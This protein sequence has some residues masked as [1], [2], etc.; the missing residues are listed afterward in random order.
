[1][2]E[3]SSKRILIV[4][5]D[6]PSHPYACVKLAK[7]LA[8]SGHDVTLGTPEGLARDQIRNGVSSW[9][10]SSSRKITVRTIGR[11]STSVHVNVRPVIDERSYSALLSG[12]WRPFPLAQKIETM[13]DEQEDLYRNLKLI[14]GEYD[15]VY[16]IHSVAGT[17]CDAV[18]S[19]YLT[20]G[21][22][23]P[24]I[25]FSSLPYDSSFYLG[26]GRD[27]DAWRMPRTI[28]ALPHV[29][30]YSS[31]KN[32]TNVVRYF[33]QLFWM[34][35]DYCLME[36]AWSRAAVRGNA[37]RAGRGLPPVADYR[38]YLQNYHV[39][40]F[41][42]VHPYVA[43]DER[44]AS[45]VTCIGAIDAR[46][47]KLDCKKE[48]DGVGESFSKWFRA[49][50][51]W[52]NKNIILASFGTGTTLNDRA[53]SNVVKLAL[54]S[55]LN[56]KYRILF[57]LRA[58]EQ[59]RLL[60]RAVLDEA[61][62]SAP[63]AAGDG[64]LEYFGGNLRIESDIPQAAVLESGKVAAFVSHMGFGGYCEG[65]RAGVP[66]VAYP[67]GCD[68]WYNACRAVDAGVALRP[69]RDMR[70]L[71][72]AV[73]NVLSE[74]EIRLTAQFLAL[75]ATKDDDANRVVRDMIDRELFVTPPPFVVDKR[76]SGKVSSCCPTC[77]S[78]REYS[79][80]TDVS[81]HSLACSSGG[82]GAPRRS[83]SNICMPRAR[84][85]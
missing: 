55:R 8:E 19:L 2:T 36:R 44:I 5:S 15:L 65:V 58:E 26:G 80:L 14:V 72:D 7:V 18:E 4:T 74:P 45:N 9:K 46:R 47:S 34:A 54:S 20:S 63:S 35:L 85:A 28:V 27:D 17:V 12:L 83:V 69:G 41:G 29:A 67:S 31:P 3:E 32:A 60:E 39:L 75:V 73:W 22:K 11:V 68:Q 6:L 52:N 13:M 30:T 23:I 77:G 56:S 62:N 57:A 49:N 70:D 79:S 53:V 16:A 1:M 24:C 51:N 48:I 59:R 66:F 81:E 78:T 61:L 84:A 10:T 25:V 82:R 43:D 42:G 50:K 40:T 37:R 33:L 76:R 38:Y 21:I 64:Y 71:E